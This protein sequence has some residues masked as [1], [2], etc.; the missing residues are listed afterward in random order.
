MDARFN[1]A[2]KFSSISSGTPS[3]TSLNTASISGTHDVTNGLMEKIKN[4]KMSPET[5]GG[6]V[7]GIILIILLVSLLWCIRHH[8]NKHHRRSMG[9]QGKN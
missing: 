9:A 1:I 6:I 8:R 5:L 2:G 4:N 3:V 7:A